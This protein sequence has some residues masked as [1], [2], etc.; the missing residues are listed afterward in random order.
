MKLRTHVRVLAPVVLSLAT[1]L[2]CGAGVPSV[3]SAREALASRLDKGDTAR[4]RLLSFEKSDGRAM[5]FMGMEAYVLIFRADAEFVSNAMFSAGSP[6]VSQGSE[7]ATAEYRQPSSGF[8]WDSFL[9]GSQGF[10]PAMK[11]DRL[12][13]GGSVTFERRESGW[14]AAGVNFTFKHDETTR[15]MEAIRRAEELQ[16]QEEARRQRLEVERAEKLAR[17]QADRDA[18]A[19]RTSF[20]IQGPTTLDYA[21]GTY[22]IG[23]LTSSDVLLF[24]LID[25][26]LKGVNVYASV[27]LNPDTD[28][29]PHGDRI[30]A[31]HLGGGGKSYSV[32]G[33]L[34]VEMRRLWPGG[35]DVF[36]EL[37]GS[38][39][40]KV[41]VTI[42]CHEVEGAPTC[43]GR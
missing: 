38:G 12:Q 7:I 22:W 16:Q 5:E 29:H 17:E 27:S 18:A 36:V 4:L 32:S 20:V 3:D 42:L 35:Q 9:A 25:G 1:A 2:G 40:V 21:S 30:G 34:R 41:G 26:D 8:S 43:R 10:R 19:E 15:D 6:L 37:T 28:N 13:I 33:D 23:R 31:G 39:D 11:G 14:V 24:K